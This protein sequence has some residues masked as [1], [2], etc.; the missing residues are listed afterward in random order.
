MLI[1]LSPAKSLDYITPSITDE[2]TQPQFIER[3]DELI[4][5][6][7][8]LSRAEIASL[9]RI[10]DP[11]AALNAER[12]AAWSKKF[13]LKNAKQAILAFDGDVYGGLDARSLNAA[14][15]TYAQSHIRILSGMYGLLRPLDLMQPYRLEMGTRLATARG[16][17]LYGFWGDTLTT[18]L[19][20]E[21]TDAK[22]KALINLASEEYFK[23]IKVN[24]LGTPVITPVFE[25]WKN[26]RYKIIS[27]YAKRARGM[28]ARYAAIN[29]IMHPERLKR[30]DM[31]GYAFDGN[32]SAE[33]RWI[34]S[35]KLVE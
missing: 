20:S 18:R 10:S 35:R 9:M 11:L 15:L 28:M 8:H 14:Q 31:E 26:G 6:L 29:G 4:S 12:Y 13:T 27:F 32:R 22:S 24:M 30:F 17:D 33:H 21:M 2:H 7:R 3:S 25:D 19:D 1:V 16:K 23:A 5:R 34:F